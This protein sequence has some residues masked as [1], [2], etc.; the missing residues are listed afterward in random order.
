MGS[1]EV[2]RSL[3]GDWVNKFY[4]GRH[5]REIDGAKGFR[6]MAAM[7]LY[8]S[9]MGSDNSDPKDLA[10]FDNE[11]DALEAKYTNY[12]CYCWIKVGCP[13]KN[14]NGEIPFLFNMLGRFYVDLVAILF[15]FSTNQF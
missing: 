6:P 8:L 3:T 14:L 10:S 7:K 9:G 5:R 2:S 13:Q 1:A 4:H 11:L 12:G 15:P